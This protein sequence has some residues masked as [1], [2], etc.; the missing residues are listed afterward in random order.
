MGLSAVGC[1]WRTGPSLARKHRSPDGPCTFHP[2]ARMLVGGG[3]I[4]QLTAFS[5]TSL[6]AVGDAMLSSILTNDN[7][8]LFFSF[9]QTL[10]FWIGS[11]LLQSP[12]TATGASTEF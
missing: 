6:L 9:T 12:R 11:V 1:T 5:P 10:A 2:P 7:S 4:S 3:R 8:S